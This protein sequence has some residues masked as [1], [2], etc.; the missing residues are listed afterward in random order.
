MVQIRRKHHEDVREVI[1]GAEA[2]A[3]WGWHIWLYSWAALG[4]AAVGLWIVA[5][6]SRGIPIGEATPSDTAEL[7]PG[8]A[9]SRAGEGEPS[10]THPRWLADTGS[11]LLG[12][13][14]RAAQN[15]AEHWVDQRIAQQRM[16]A[17]TRPG[18]CPSAGGAEWPDGRPA[19]PGRH[20]RAGE[21]PRSNLVSGGFHDDRPHT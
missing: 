1:A 11:F 14:V 21:G 4:A 17:A 3:G 5:N 7:P 19:R 2:V 6:R 12:M 18:P 8:V 9:E 13:A 20:S 10:K 15:Y 16:K